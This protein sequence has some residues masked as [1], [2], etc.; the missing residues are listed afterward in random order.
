MSY[1]AAKMHQIRFRLGLRPNPAGE[2]FRPS[3]DLRGVGYFYRG[4][5]D[6][7]A[8]T[9]LEGAR[10][11]LNLA[12]APIFLFSAALDLTISHQPP[13]RLIPQTV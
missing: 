1:F 10:G 7:E 11:G 3:M 6:Q 4:G 12:L 13:N 9:V 8:V 5:K 2:R